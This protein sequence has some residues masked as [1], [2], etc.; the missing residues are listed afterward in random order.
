MTVDGNTPVNQPLENALV[1]LIDGR[2]DGFYNQGYTDELGNVTLNFDPSEISGELSITVTKFGH[3][4]HMGTLSY[5]SEHVSYASSQSVIIDGNVTVGET[6][7]LNVPIFYNGS[8]TFNNV[9]ATLTSDGSVNFIND[10]VN[11]ETISNGSNSADESFIVEITELQDH[12]SDIN[13]FI[14]LNDDTGNEFITNINFNVESFDIN[15]LDAV[16]VNDN[17]NNGRLDPGESSN[18]LL[19]YENNGVISTPLFTCTLSTVSEDFSI[20]ANETVNLILSN[21]ELIQ[22][23]AH[24]H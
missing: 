7:N 2:T 10:Q 24:L 1:T 9:T 17:N 19:N 20:Q 16:I 15:I 6:L 21:L 14:T 8:N 13:F 22:T 12:N 23:L 3:K 4:P 18:I 5:D 11:Y